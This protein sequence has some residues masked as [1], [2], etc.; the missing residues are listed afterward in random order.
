MATRPVG[1]IVDSGLMQGGANPELPEVEVEIAAPED[2]SGGAE[3]IDDG[4]GGAIV[5]SI[6]GEIEVMAEQYDHNANLAEMLDDAA[7]GSLSSELISLY[8]EDY[9]SRSE[10][11][12]TYVKGLDLLGIQHDERSRPFEGASGVTHPLI[13]ESVTQFQ[14][15]AYKELLPAGGP[16]SVNLVG[17]QNAEREA[18]AHTSM[19]PSRDPCLSLFQPKIWLYH[20][21]LV[22]YRQ[23]LV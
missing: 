7:L 22:I 9:D 8:N 19:R 6:T 16:V 11:E 21:L 20:I 18:Q 12:Q 1:S 5:Q 15:Q 14:S 2:F 13:S 10:W 17:V 23:R 4:Q 3:I